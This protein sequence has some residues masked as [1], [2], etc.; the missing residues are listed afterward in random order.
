MVKIESMEK[1]AEVAPKLQERAYYPWQFQYDVDQPEGYH[2]V[3]CSIGTGLPDV[4][5]VTHS[6][7]VREAIL[8]YNREY[9]R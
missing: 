1:W 2:A 3:F 7:D 4:E 6:P 8:K 5:I 9:K